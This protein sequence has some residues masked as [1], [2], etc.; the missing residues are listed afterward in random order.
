M[1]TIIILAFLLLNTLQLIYV[2]IQNRQL[3]QLKIELN[4]KNAIITDKNAVINE[5]QKFV[6]IQNI[7][8]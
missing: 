1:D 4:D 7:T 6:E 2:F 5:L 3:N 8:D